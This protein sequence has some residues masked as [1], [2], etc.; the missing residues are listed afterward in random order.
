VGPPFGTFG[1]DPQDERS[2]QRAQRCASPSAIP[3]YSPSLSM[4]FTL[5]HPTPPCVA[6][7][8]HPLHR[9]TDFS[10]YY[11]SLGTFLYMTEGFER[12]QL[13]Y[14]RVAP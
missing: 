8:V 4:P 1:A 2:E 9:V 3:I 7:S 12:Y 5:P 10:C 13:T 6:L 14:S 11:D